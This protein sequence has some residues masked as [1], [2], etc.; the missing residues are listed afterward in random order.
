MVIARV[1]WAIHMGYHRQ[2][3]MSQLKDKL[4]HLET[5]L[6]TLIEGG[7]SRLFPSTLHQAELAKRLI[8]EMRAGV[9]TRPDGQRIAPNLYIL[10]INSAS[11]KSLIEDSALLEELAQKIQLAGDEE[12]FVF[13]S[14]PVIRLISKTEAGPQS[15]H[16]SAQI[17]IENLPE[18]TDVEVEATTNKRT[19]SSNAYLIVDGT[20]IFPLNQTVVNIGR[21]SDNQ[22]IIEDGRI[23]RVHAQIRAIN[24]RYVIFDL[25]STSGTYVNDQR[26]NQCTLYPGDVISLAGVPLVFGQDEVTLDSTQRMNSSD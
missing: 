4:S 11:G 3:I 10:E 14:P 26:I 17:S 18:T 19:V 8:A 15:I 7:S 9:K 16:V 21:R 13:L 20:Q 6:Q 5:S 23:S 24:G 22:L 1:T 2:I 25:D 12:K